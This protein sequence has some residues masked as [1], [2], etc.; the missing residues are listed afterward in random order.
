MSSHPNALLIASIRPPSGQ[1]DEFLQEGEDLEVGGEFYCVV[2]DENSDMGICPADVEHFCIYEY[3][4]YGWC[5][6]LELG[7]ALAKID[8]FNTIVEDYCRIHNCTY[9]LHLSANFY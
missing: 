9:K 8:K 7:E 3:L 4:T 6:T 1:V 5:E 2:V